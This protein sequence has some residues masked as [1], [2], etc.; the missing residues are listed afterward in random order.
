MSDQRTITLEA[1]GRRTAVVILPRKVDRPSRTFKSA[2]E[3]LAFAEQLRQQHGW[4]IR[5][6]L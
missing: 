1:W 5:D 4:P 6:C 2:V 3:A